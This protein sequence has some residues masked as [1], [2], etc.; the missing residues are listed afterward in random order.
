MRLSLALSTAT[1]RQAVRTA[2]LANSRRAALAAVFRRGPTGAEELLF[3]KR[4]TYPTDPWSGHVALPG[5][6]AEP[7]DEGEDEATAAR[8]A[9]EEVGIDLLDGTW[10][11]LGRVARD[12][13]IFPR[14]RPLTI[15]VF[16][17]AQLDTPPSVPPPEPRLP[18]VRIRRT[19]LSGVHGTGWWSTRRQPTYMTNVCMQGLRRG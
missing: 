2:T 18:E 17:F 4:A 8:E 15:S 19:G 14:G 10:A 11:R 3:I 6:G 13:T 5:G 7:A 9:R 1:G 16:G 12:R